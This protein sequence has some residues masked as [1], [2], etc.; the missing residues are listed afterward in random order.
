MGRKRP[1]PGRRRM[2]LK[3]N[4]SVDIGGEDAKTLFFA[5][6]CLWGQNCNLGMLAYCRFVFG[7]SVP[8]GFLG[9]GLS[10]L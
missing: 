5:F 4:V 3:S 1:R 9:T 8:I 2:M 7:A 10:L 6:D